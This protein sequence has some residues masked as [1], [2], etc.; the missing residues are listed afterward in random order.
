[1]Y[2]ELRELTF[3]LFVFH[4]ANTVVMACVLII[5][6][7]IM[8]TETFKKP[9]LESGTSILSIHVCTV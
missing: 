1:M 8:T 5:M 7:I 9:P 3:L 4:N 2:K 6:I